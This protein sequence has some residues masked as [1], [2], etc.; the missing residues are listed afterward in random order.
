[1][2]D[3]GQFSG[4]TLRIDH[5]G[6]RELFGVAVPIEAIDLVFGAHPEVTVSELR[7]AIVV[8]SHDWDQ[9][10]F[11][12]QR[13]TKARDSI[14]ESVA[15]ASERLTEATE[16]ERTYM[17]QTLADAA[18]YLERSDEDMMHLRGEEF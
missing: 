11:Q 1:M 8:M 2:S 9:A 7:H 17:I 3:P 16:P 13:L 15:I 6:M 5:P 14:V 4:K 12:L 10:E 18:D